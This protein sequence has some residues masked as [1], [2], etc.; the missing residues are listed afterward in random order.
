MSEFLSVKLGLFRAALL[1]GDFRIECV[2]DQCSPINRFII[3][4]ADPADAAANQIQPGRHRLTRPPTTQ[5]RDTEP[6]SR[7]NSTEGVR[8]WVR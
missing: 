6:D 1:G 4:I 3:I 5:A 2:V 7:I 8:R